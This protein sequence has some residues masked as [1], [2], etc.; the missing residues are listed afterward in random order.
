MYYAELFQDSEGRILRLYAWVDEGSAADDA[1]P[2][3]DMQ[4]E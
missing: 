1:W 3:P 2:H 4:R